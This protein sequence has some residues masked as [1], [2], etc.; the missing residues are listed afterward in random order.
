MNKFDYEA[1]WQQVSKY[2]G[3]NLPES[4]LKII[5][6]IYKEAKAENNADQLA[7]ALVHR[8]QVRASKEEFSFEKN[9]A[10]LRAEISQATFPLKPLLHSMMAELYWQYYT[11]N[12][13]RFSNRSTVANFQQ[14]DL[15]TWSLSKIVSE[16]AIHHQAALQ[17]PEKLQQ[18]SAS[19]YKEMIIGGNSLGKALRPTLYDFLA[20]RAL[21]LYMN[22]EP[23]LIKPEEQFV[24]AEAAYLGSAEEFV[25]SS[26]KPR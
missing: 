7:K 3:Q 14:D 2:L 5:E 6:Q 11:K 26:P 12:R 4:A 17:E 18:I 16:V 20:H 25:N 8:M 1:S 22:Q 15:A 13:W 19:F 24:I 9:L 21:A 23:E 10:E